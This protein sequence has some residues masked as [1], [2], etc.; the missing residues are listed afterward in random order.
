MATKLLNFV[1]RLF[2]WECLPAWGF[3]VA[4]I[5]V[6]QLVGGAL[7]LAGV[8]G[9]FPLL[10]TLGGAIFAALVVSA[11]YF[12][13]WTILVLAIREHL[14]QLPP[15]NVIV[16]V[17]KGGAIVGAVLARLIAERHNKEPKLIILDRQFVLSGKWMNDVFVS[18][19]RDAI[20]GQ[21]GTVLLVASEVH[22]GTTMKEASER[23]IAAG[24]T[25]FQSFAVIT[26]PTSRFQIDHSILTSNSR[27]VLPWPES[28]MRIAS[29][30]SLLAAANNCAPIANQTHA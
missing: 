21:H 9:F 22:S 16:G 20:D 23:L 10:W 24:V 17:S 5:T 8:T 14:D 15:A 19:L 29:K 1:N 27:K 6:F 11:L 2:N 12:F 18:N 3:I 13:R 30:Q 28:P 26:S 4:A 7:Q 25:N